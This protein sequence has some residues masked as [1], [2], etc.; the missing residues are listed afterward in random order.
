MDSVCWTSR[1]CRLHRTIPAACPSFVFQTRGFS[2][3]FQSVIRCR[4]TLSSRRVCSS[5]LTLSI[6]ESSGS[7]SF[8]LFPRHGKPPKLLP[9]LFSFQT[10]SISDTSIA[11]P[12]R[13]LQCKYVIFRLTSRH[14]HVIPY[15]NLL[16][17]RAAPSPTGWPHELQHRQQQPKRDRTRAEPLH[18]CLQRVATL[19]SRSAAS[20][21]P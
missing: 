10:L 20:S 18:G 9:P 4:M 7:S 13:L 6:T 3:W 12:S 5:P 1:S 14:S 19:P 2:T 16:R 21:P 17:L 15:P 8:H 11:R